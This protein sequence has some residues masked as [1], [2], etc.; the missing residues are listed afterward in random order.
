MSARRR[1]LAGATMFALAW[2]G[3]AT[4]SAQERGID[5]HQGESLV[6][7]VLPNKAAAV[8]LQLEADT[9]GV[10]FNEHYLR[11][12]SDGSVT[13][14]VFG[15]DDEIAAL[16]AAGFEVGVT[17]EGKS[18]WRSRVRDRQADVRAERRAD[19]AA[20]DDPVVTPQAHEDEIVVLR[21]DYFENYAGRFLSVEAK[22]RRG[23]STPDTATY[24]GPTL[25]LSW[26]RGAGTPI[27]APPKQMNVNID[28]DTTPDTY[29]EH[30][31]LIR[32]GAADSASPPRPT[33][34]RI[35]SSTGA[36]IE[37]PVN[38]WLGGGLPPM[39]SRFLKDFTTRYMDPT[40][41][42]GRFRELATEFPNLAQLIPLPN[43]TNGYQRRAQALMAGTSDPDDSLPNNP[44]GQEAATRAV[45][46]TSRAWGHEGATRSPPSS[47]TRASS[48]RR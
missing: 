30:R 19:A 6:E 18:S 13:A 34:I 16:D 2:T 15:T 31:E 22:D 8:R 27:D 39:S 36:T 4:S 9:Y 48:T 26:N 7:V 23:G 46:L 41:V 40:E 11:R 38:I 29:I 37:A 28:P 45:V 17:I 47:S 5:P 44:A 33:R 21:V 1:W 32:I 3:A 10:D 35:G 43:A 12:S 42:Y 14:T 20:L 24:V 25:S